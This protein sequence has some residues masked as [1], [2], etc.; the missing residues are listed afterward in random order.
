MTIVVLNN[1]YVFMCAFYLFVYGLFD[2]VIVPV[3]EPPS[4]NA[5]ISDAT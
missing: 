1:I 5:V 4:Q 2:C 3:Y